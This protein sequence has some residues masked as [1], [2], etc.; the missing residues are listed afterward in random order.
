MRTKILMK[1]AALAVTLMI[2][3]TCVGVAAA[4]DSTVDDAPATIDG[5]VANKFGGTEASR[6]SEILG[7][8]IGGSSEWYAMALSKLGGYDLSEY[9]TSLLEY[10]SENEILSPSTRE[11]FALTL[12][13]LKCDDLFIEATLNDSVGQQ[14]IMSYVFGLH[15]LN[16]GHV[17]DITDSKTVKEKLLSLQLSDGGWAVMGEHSDVDV[18]AMVLQSLAPHKNE[19]EVSAAIDAALSL[20]SNR[21]S[22]NGDFASYDVFSAESTA[23]V[24]TALSCLGIDQNADM[25]FIKGNNTV[26]DGLLRYRLA[27][28]TFSHDGSDTSNG[29]A[30]VQAFYSAVSYVCMKEGKGSLYV[31]GS[32][33]DAP[34]QDSTDGT[35]S[36]SD[37]T[38]NETERFFEAHRGKIIACGAIILLAV[39]ASG[40]LFIT[41]RRNLKNYLIIFAIMAALLTAAV[42]I[43]F[44]SADSYYGSS[45]APIED[46]IGEVTLLIRCDT[47]VGKRDDVPENGELLSLSLSIGNGDTVRDVL[48]R[49]A[50]EN[51]IKIDAD[52]GKNYY[53]RAIESISE[54]DF[55]D[56]SGWMYRVNG[57]FPSVGCSEY[58]LRDNDIIEWLYTTDMGEDLR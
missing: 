41:K 14:G 20:L 48:V 58:V 16:N 37:A 22:E 13:A 12:I 32:D 29:T 1:A 40:V 54:F 35:T 24:L 36:V 10:L 50:R 33:G 57:E 4:A 31:F 26:L 18:T 23:Q 38:A 55:G 34:A 7:E 39:I 47:V 8:D 49:A 44:E 46:P 56:L 2:L 51:G 15:I 45:L 43:R 30:T 3:V 11:K 28:G 17:S 53:V 6:I 19:N 21:Q 27:D 5:I 52:G 25:R 42:L 9:R